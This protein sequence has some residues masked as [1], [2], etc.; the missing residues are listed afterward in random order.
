M[1]L[2][3][4]ELKGNSNISSGSGQWK[5]LRGQKWCHLMTKNH[6]VVKENAPIKNS[7]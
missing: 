1:S 7:F 5:K 3:T 6:F 2:I 4:Y